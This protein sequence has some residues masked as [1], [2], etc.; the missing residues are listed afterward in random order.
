MTPEPQTNLIGARVAV[1]STNYPHDQARHR[2][3][4]L[5]GIVPVD[6]YRVLY[7]IQPDD[8]EGVGGIGNARSLY[9]LLEISNVDESCLVMLDPQHPKPGAP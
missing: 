6:Q 4:V 7:L 3:G 2:Y 9:R 1:V 8:P 5:R